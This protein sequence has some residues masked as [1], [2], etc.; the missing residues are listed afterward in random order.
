MNKKRILSL[1]LTVLVLMP[2]AV[3]AK[4]NPQGKP[5]TEKKVVE[6]KVTTEESKKVE[7][8]STTLEAAKPS[9]EKT[10]GQEKKAEAMQKKDEKKAQ[11]ETFKTTMRAKHEQMKALRD[12][13]KALRKQVEQ[14]T[15][16]LSAIISDL[17]AGKKTLPADQL[18][19]LLAAAQ[20]L[21]LDG[22]E[23]KETAE[24]VTE[25]KETETKVKG[26]DFN[27][28][29]VSMDKVIAKY[30]K[31]LD[32][33]KQLN[34]DLDA[35]LAIARLAIV[36]TPVDTTPATVPAPTQDPTTPATGETTTPATT[37]QTTTGGTTQPTPDT[38]TT[39]TNTAPAS[40]IVAMSFC[41]PRSWTR[42]LSS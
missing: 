15:E 29:L 22:V 2:G 1:V 26:A 21:K 38:S 34:T 14:K 11:I 5:A 33:L 25:A 36:P 30:Q 23:V 31:R 41:E 7:K 4:G 19:A 35:A 13:T 24:I 17:Q 10:K 9:S 12:E 16:E 42:V 8:T 39:D 40:R 18:T 3:F 6:Q 37:D 27:N 20:N 32:A 28:A